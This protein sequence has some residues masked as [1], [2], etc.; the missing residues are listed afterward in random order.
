M[1]SV[2]SVVDKSMYVNI[3]TVSINSVLFLGRIQIT[4]I[5]LE[6]YIRIVREMAV[7]P[8]YGVH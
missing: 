1:F 3:I 5:F 2:K 8:M 6:W 7:G 4:V